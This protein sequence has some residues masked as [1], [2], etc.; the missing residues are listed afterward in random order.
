MENSFCRATPISVIVSVPPGGNIDVV[1]PLGP[2]IAAI[3]GS[4]WFTILPLFAEA[5][6]ESGTGV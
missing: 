5:R 3:D 2:V 6:T 1:V 4:I